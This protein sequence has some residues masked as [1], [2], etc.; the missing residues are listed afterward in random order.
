MTESTTAMAHPDDVRGAAPQYALSAR[1]LTSGYDRVAVLHDVDVDV[2]AGEVVALL[3]ANGAGKT[4]LI[5]TL[6][7]ELR[8]LSG[9]VRIDDAEVTD[10]LEDRVR[11]SGLS[12]ITQERSVFMTLTARQNIRL[13]GGSDE[14][15]LTLF[16][17]LE[18]HMGRKVGQ[19]SGGQ[20]Q[21]VSVA[22][23]I[24]A[25]PRV[26][27]ADEVSLGLAPML[28]DRLLEVLAEVAH[29]DGVGVVIVEQFVDKAL[30][31]SDRAYVLS[32]GVVAMHGNSKEMN[33]RR[34][35]LHSHYL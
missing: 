2:R 25:N 7:G 18:P 3:G 31:F 10:G 34:E 15:A 29:R 24:C 26:I 21:M 22:R 17:E 9:T 13:G 20:Q 12:V 32:R 1:G 30:R 23:A 27:L 16:P 19:L 33:E 6:A 28:V 4:T 35:E 14:R 5:M 8:P 11:G